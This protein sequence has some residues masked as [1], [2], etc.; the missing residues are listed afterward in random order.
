MHITDRIRYMFLKILVFVICF[1]CG[2]CILVF[3]LFRR[4]TDIQIFWFKSKRIM[5]RIK[6]YEYFFQLYPYTIKNNIYIVWFLIR[7]LFLFEPKNL[8]FYWNNVCEF[9]I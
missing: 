5:N 8:E 3:D 7:Y 9:Y 6:I 1:I 4:V 2:Y